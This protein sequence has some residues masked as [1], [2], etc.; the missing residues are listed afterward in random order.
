VTRKLKSPGP[1]Y[2]WGSAGAGPWATGAL[3]VAGAVAGNARRATGLL[4]HREAAHNLN[5]LT[6]CLKK[7]LPKTQGTYS[8]LFKAGHRYSPDAPD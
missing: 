7:T 2:S 4:P 1:P 8:V 5:F 3:P 6:W